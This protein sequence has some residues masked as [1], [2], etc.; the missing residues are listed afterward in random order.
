MGQ[1]GDHVLLSKQTVLRSHYINYEYLIA[2]PAIINIPDIYSHHNLVKQN[3][4]CY[5]THV[6]LQSYQQKKPSV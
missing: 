1:H 2:N 5:F 4:T 3:N 6:S